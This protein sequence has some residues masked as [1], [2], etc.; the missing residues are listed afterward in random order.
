MGDTT[1]TFLGSGDV[2]GSGGR[3]QT[4]IHVDTGSSTFLIDCGASSMPAMKKQGVDPNDIETIFITHLH[5]DHFGGLTYFILDA[6]HASKRTEPITIVGPPGTKERVKRAMDAM[7]PD[8][9]DV[10][11]RFEIRF[12]EYESGVE[13]TTNGVELRPYEVR[14]ACGAPPHALR[15]EADGTAIGYSG[16]TEWRDVLVDAA[17]DT[18]LFISEAYFYEREVPYHLSYR[19]LMSHRDELECDRLIVTHMNWDMLDRLDELEV[20]YAEDGLS[21]TV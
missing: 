17:R 21:V 16:D 4:C 8:L 19:T 7:V 5:G 2:F 20:E 13:R 10:D 14:H 9:W 12:I 3:L 1:V 18:D 6:Q 11:Q 15:L